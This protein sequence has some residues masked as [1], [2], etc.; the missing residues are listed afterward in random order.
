MLRHT[1][2]TGGTAKEYGG[3]MAKPLSRDAPSLVR[4][5]APRA[6]A[7]AADSLPPPI[8]LPAIAI[9]QHLLAA[10]RAGDAARTLD[11]LLRCAWEVEPQEQILCA[12]LPLAIAIEEGGE[13]ALPPAEVAKL[14]GFV[15]AT[16]RAQIATLPP[17]MEPLWVLPATDGEAHL[18]WML[19]A[20]LSR[21]GRPARPWLWPSQPPSAWVTVGRRFVPARSGPTC[22]GHYHL[23][24][25]RG[26]LSLAGLASDRRDPERAARIAARARALRPAL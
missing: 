1:V 24:A 12:W 3:T 15:A 25:A 16:L 7:S 13:R 11:A 23:T 10:V 2:R 17:C 4:R 22:K 5:D 20:L 26:G 21:R 19:A 18:A 6:T 8:G 9:R 14:N